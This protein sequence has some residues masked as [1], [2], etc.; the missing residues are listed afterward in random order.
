MGKIDKWKIIV[1]S[2][3]LTIGSIGIGVAGADIVTSTPEAHPVFTLSNA[4]DGNLENFTMIVD[5]YAFVDGSGY[6]GNYLTLPGY[7]Q[8]VG[9]VIDVDFGEVR[10]ITDIEWLP[11]QWEWN[12]SQ[13]RDFEVLV[14]NDGFSW[15]LVLAV[16]DAPRI[17]MSGEPYAIPYTWASYI[18]NATG[19]Y[20]RFH[21]IETY[22]WSSNLQL[23]EIDFLTDAPS[24]PG[25]IDAVATSTPTAHEF[26]TLSKALDRD[27]SSFAMVG[28]PLPVDIDVD[29]GESRCISEL[30][31]LPRQ[32]D[33]TAQPKDFEVLVSDDGVSWSLV[34]SVV[35]APPVPF[36]GEPYARPG[37][38]ASYTVNAAGR[39]LRFHVVGTYGN[40][41]VYYPLDTSTNLQLAELW[42]VTETVDLD[43]LCAE[44]GE[45]VD[46][47][48]PTNGQYKNHGDYVSQV[49]HFVEEEIS[50]MCLTE[51]QAEEL[52]SCVVHVRAQSDV[53]KKRRGN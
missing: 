3:F 39:Y 15:N 7:E 22:D 24:G 43:A 51:E 42:F 19:Q 30:S 44:L 23:A 6:T 34:L 49:A 35:D 14:S 11:R 40:W 46:D 41:P 2:L 5:G 25:P 9:S 16:D 32:S 53:G 31:Y 17:P 33:P 18:V 52:S 36:L 38:S 26:F 13:P 10:D 50:G 45:A 12:N 47:A 20:L 4:L 27:P 29:F 21:V 8:N 1:F 28:P 37:T 48:V